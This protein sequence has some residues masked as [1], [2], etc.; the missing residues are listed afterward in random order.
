M[1]DMKPPVR[2][3]RRPSTPTRAIARRSAS[4]WRRPGP[5]RCKGPSK[6][7][8]EVPAPGARLSSAR[9]P[10]DH[11]PARLRGPIVRG[12]RGAHRPPRRHGT[13]AA[14]P[15]A[16]RVAGRLKPILVDPHERLHENARVARRRGRR[17]PRSGGPRRVRRS[18]APVRL[19]RVGA[20]V[21]DVAARFAASRG[22]RSRAIGTEGIDRGGD[23]AARSR[24]RRRRSVRVPA[25]NRVL[26]AAPG[27]AERGRGRSRPGHDR[28]VRIPSASGP[29]RLPGAPTLPP[30][31]RFVRGA[32]ARGRVAQP[33]SECHGRSRGLDLVLA[34]ALA[35][36]REGLAGGGEANGAAWTR[37]RTI[38]A[39]GA[40]AVDD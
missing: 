5:I 28:V 27:V 26:A 38:A 22:I 9:I 35:G 6:R 10:G 24:T 23:P 7:S 4:R 30:Q 32:G 19:V 3:S 20:R 16:R 15:R 8:A 37:M 13:L 33:R 2:R 21:R 29:P 12:D 40:A 31:R 34:G 18:R 1:F 39:A 14:S 36:S 11:H 17:T 25:T